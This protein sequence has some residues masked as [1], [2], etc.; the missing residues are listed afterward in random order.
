MS[1]KYYLH[2]AIKSNQRRKRL[3]VV[4]V[5]I[6]LALVLATI[7]V[8]SAYYNNLKPVSQN[9]SSQEITIPEGASVDTIIKILK[10]N[11]LIKSAWAFRLYV[12]G[13]DAASVLQAGTYA[14]SQN[15][16]VNEIVSI[17]SHGKVVT[18]LMTILPG[19]SIM[20]LKEAFVNA[21]FSQS[22]VDQAFDASTYSGVPVLVDKPVSASL[23]GFLFPDS[24]QKSGN[25]NPRNIIMAA[26]EEMQLYLTPDVRQKFANQG[27]S[28]YQGLILASMVEKEADSQE[29]RNQI[30]QVF[31]SR[32]RADMKLGSDV[33][34]FYGAELAGVEPSVNYDSAYNT[35]L[36]AGLPPTPISTVSESSLKAVANPASTD[37]LYFVAGDDHKVYFS[38]TLEDH[39]A[40]KNAHCNQLCQ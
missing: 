7:G 32:L 13:Q 19:K 31:L 12:Y 38:K 39:E 29:D 6:V 18:N 30:A 15:M 21:G 34:A 27:L 28:T 10:D 40:L 20:Q 14:L 1:K 16:S 9:S 17:I 22:D 33:T 24:Y 2:Q 26:L 4:F 8:R 37:W 11:D 3:L 25:T 35:R 5:A 23:E 36:H